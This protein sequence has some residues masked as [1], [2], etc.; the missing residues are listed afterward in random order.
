M[1][2]NKKINH[3]LLIKIELLIIAVC[4]VIGALQFIKLPPSIKE[5]IALATTIKPE[6]FTELY[7]ENHASL[8]KQITLYKEASF[9]FTI[10]NFEGK[11][12]VYFYETEIVN[13]DKI[14]KLNHGEIFLTS[15]ESKTIREKFTLTK[16][17]TKIMVRVKVINNNQEIHFWVEQK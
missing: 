15:N 16:T 13:G 8:P 17:F 6:T 5:A 1:A 7:F 3:K 2:K 10:H 11:N 12:I 9:N 14:S 4:F